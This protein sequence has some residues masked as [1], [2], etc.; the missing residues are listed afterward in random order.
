MNQDVDP[1]SALNLFVVAMSGVFALI[2]A[3]VGAYVG[4]LLARRTEYEKWLRQERSTVFSEF[5]TKF[6]EADQEAIK[7]LSDQDCT[8]NQ[9][10]QKITALFCRL[11]GP[12]NV[13]RLY[14]KKSDRE[15]FS[16]SLSVYWQLHFE[17][18]WLPA[19]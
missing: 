8:G 9:R 2:G 13:V 15:K 1:N 10:D 14:L 5:L 3:L 7:I 4:A 18:G 17:S 11:D 6:N 12:K 19:I 16:H